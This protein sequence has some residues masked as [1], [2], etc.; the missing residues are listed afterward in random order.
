VKSA[1]NY[2]RLEHWIVAKQSHGKLWFNLNELREHFRNDSET[3]LKQL[4]QRLTAQGK[5]VSVF[6]GFYVIVPPQYSSKGIL[7]PVMFI[8]GLMHYL[9]RKYYLSL[10]NAAALHGASHQQPQSYFVTTEYP[11]LRATNK[12]GIRINYISTKQLP[13][14]SLIEK[15][16][17]ETGYIFVSNPILT[18]VDLISFEKRIGGMNRAA[19]VINEL[20]EQITPRKIGESLIGYAHVTSL[21]RLGL[22]LEEFIH[23]KDLADKL[24]RECRKAGLTFYQIPLKASGDKKS[25]PI[26]EKWKIVIN[27][28][29]EIDK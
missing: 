13:T 24:Y 2:K 26:N 25:G 16:K 5:I 18:A 19:T 6:K 12:K 15:R 28:E 22:L 17:T 29:I 14:D 23:R 7:P 1:V 27:T 21:Q 4:L 3:S 11:V 8:D 9:N 20:V 10:L